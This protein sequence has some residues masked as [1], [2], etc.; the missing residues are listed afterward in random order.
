MN[1][2]EKAEVVTWPE[3]YYVF[4]EKAGP[5][6]TNAGAAWQTAHSLVPELLEHNKITAYLSLYKM[7]PQVYRAGFALEA[8][9]VELPKA[10]NYEKFPGGKYSKFEYTGPYSGLGEATGR[11]VRIV[12]ETEIPLRDDFNIEHY[13]TD[14]RV[15]PE[16][17]SITA[18]L[19]PTV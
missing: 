9:P 3:T 13:V 6:S 7:D 15:T 17:E 19:F 10:L 5:I 16:P 8:P 2:T 1:I 11:L 12:N 18:I 14:P 4:I